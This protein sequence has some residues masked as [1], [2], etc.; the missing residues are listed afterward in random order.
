MK[1]NQA[2]ESMDFFS[3]TEL[4]RL[5]GEIADDDDDD[6]AVVDVEVVPVSMLRVPKR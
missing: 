4:E 6:V 5:E 1:P 2:R 3:V